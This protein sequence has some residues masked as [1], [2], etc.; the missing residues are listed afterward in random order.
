M[1]FAIYIVESK[2]VQLNFLYIGGAKISH[3]V[4]IVLILYE[5]VQDIKIIV[6]ST[7]NVS[8]CKIVIYSFPP[9]YKYGRKCLIW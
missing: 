7:V 8:E 1:I 3:N 5:I 9:S 6:S 4:K 2:L